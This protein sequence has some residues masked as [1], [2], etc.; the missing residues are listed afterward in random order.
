MSMLF[1]IIYLTLLL[2]ALNAGNFMVY[3]KMVVSRMVV[4]LFLEWMVFEN[5]LTLNG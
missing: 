2:M 1:R 5:L 3:V 4:D